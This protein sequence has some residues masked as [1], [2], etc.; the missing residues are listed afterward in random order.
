MERYRLVI[1]SD[2]DTASRLSLDAPSVKLALLVADIN[3]SGGVA[4]LWR[5]GKL[6]ARLRKRHGL[7]H[8]LWELA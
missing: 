2:A 1:H 3:M 7:R 6:L 8:P 5:E 4:E